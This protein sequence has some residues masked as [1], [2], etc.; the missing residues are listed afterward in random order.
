MTKEDQ[1]TVRRIVD[2]AIRLSAF[3]KG[4]SRNK[5]VLYRRLRRQGL[6]SKIALEKMFDSRKVTGIG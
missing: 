4:I 6:S 3:L 1:D 5:R 2:N